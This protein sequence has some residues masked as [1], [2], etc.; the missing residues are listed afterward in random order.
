MQ[1]IGD[2]LLHTMQKNQCFSLC[3]FLLLTEGKDDGLCILQS[4]S[5][6]ESGR[7][8]RDKGN[9]KSDESIME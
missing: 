2:M 6:Q 1:D 8:L 9:F 3:A 7:R 4:E 5:G